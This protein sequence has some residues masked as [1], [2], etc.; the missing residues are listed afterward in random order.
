MELAH[1]LAE[2]EQLDGGIGL[3]DGSEELEEAAEAAHAEEG[4]LGAG[5]P[6]AGPE[7]EGDFP[8]HPLLR[9]RADELLHHRERR[10][11]VGF[12]G[13][14]GAGAVAGDGAGAGAALP[15]CVAP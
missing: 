11:P 7:G 13:G 3:G 5:V 2:S 14:V 4:E 6:E 8:V 12:S 10:V 1:G 9:E 15:Q